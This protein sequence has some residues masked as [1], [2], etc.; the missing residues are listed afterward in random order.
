MRCAAWFCILV[1]AGPLTGA[2]DE[3]A[4]IRLLRDDQ[5]SKWTGDRALWTLKTDEIRGNSAGQSTPLVY[6][7]RAFGDYVLRFSAQVQTGSVRILL[8][9][10]WFAWVLEIGIEK[11]WLRG[12][13][14]DGFVVFLNKPEEWAEYE[15]RVR[16]GGVNLLRN[17]KPAGLGF[18]ASHM[19]GTGGISLQLADTDQASKV[20]IQKLRIRPSP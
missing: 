18:S 14:G 5:L 12:G 2:D 6:K 10:V 17:G 13:G 1:F 7:G 3:E 8:R 4:F 9:N 15:V 11:V 16:G 20:M 19:P